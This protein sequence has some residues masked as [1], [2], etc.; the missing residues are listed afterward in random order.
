MMLL[1]QVHLDLARSFDE[2]KESPYGELSLRYKFD[3]D[4]L[5]IEV[6]NARNLMAMD[7]NGNLFLKNLNF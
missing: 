3:G 1:L 2:H 6:I 4:T 7:S 5:K